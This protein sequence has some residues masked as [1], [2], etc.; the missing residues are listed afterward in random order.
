VPYYKPLLSP[1]ARAARRVWFAWKYPGRGVRCPVCEREFKSYVGSATGNCPGCDTR[2][3]CRLMWLFLRDQRPDLLG[4]SNAILQIA[5]DPGLE[6]VF[7]SLRGIRYLS[8]D[9]YEP[10]AM[11]RLDLT[12]LDL[13][14]MCFDVVICIHVLAH[15]SNDRKALREIWRVLRPGGV[16]LIMTPVDTNS[17]VTYEDPSI[18]D[19]DARDKAFGEWDFVRKYGRD[20]DERLTE[21]G[22]EVA[23]VRPAENMDDEERKVLGLWNDRIFICKRERR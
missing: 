1:I 13:P 6:R 10:E 7:R 20:F 16:A 5:P 2:E 12:R 15:I 19:H 14:D 17:A 18:I 3:R 11:V 8:G 9:L 4:G 22:F 23:V 21:A